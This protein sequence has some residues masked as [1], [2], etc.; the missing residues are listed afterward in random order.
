MSGPRPLRDYAESGYVTVETVDA[1]FVASFDPT[2]RLLT[3]RRI[4]RHLT[5]AEAKALQDEASQQ[6]GLLLIY[7]E[8]PRSDHDRSPAVD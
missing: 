5:L 2:G 6:G 7:P 8:R 3:A 4:A 1:F